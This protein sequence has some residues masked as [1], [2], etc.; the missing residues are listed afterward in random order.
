MFSRF[1]TAFRSEHEDA[2]RDAVLIALASSSILTFYG[3]LARMRWW[4]GFGLIPAVLFGTEIL[5]DGFPFVP[6][7]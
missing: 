6:A 5:P 7:G 4:A 1:T 3:P 2:D